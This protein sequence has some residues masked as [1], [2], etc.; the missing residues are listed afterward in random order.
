MPSAK[1][2]RIDCRKPKGHL[3]Q[4]N[5]LTE[6]EQALL[7]EQ[8][9][10]S[11][12]LFSLLLSG[13]DEHEGESN[14]EFSTRRRAA[15]ERELRQRVRQLTHAVDE[16]FSQRGRR[17]YYDIIGYTEHTLLQEARGQLAGQHDQHHCYLCEPMRSLGWTR[18]R[19]LSEAALALYLQLHGS[20]LQGEV[21]N[22]LQRR[23]DERKL[24]PLNPIENNGPAFALLVGIVREGVHAL[25]EDI[26]KPHLNRWQR[27]PVAA[28]AISGGDCY[29]VA[30][31][32]ARLLVRH[33]PPRP[34]GPA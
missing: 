19:A 21:L 32:V 15:Q 34:E 22:N 8:K 27:T 20:R 9:E 12:E 7:Q 30:E 11:R 13:K 4:M 28:R 33:R 16:I 14:D 10:V 18:R 6:D 2:L 25:V 31:S 26:L 23:Y 17:T 3:F 29:L 24:G 5:D 1:I